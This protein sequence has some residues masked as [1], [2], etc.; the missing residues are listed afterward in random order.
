MV[1]ALVVRDG[2]VVGSGY[3]RR[4]GGPHAE[5]EALDGAGDQARGAALFVTLEPCSHSGRTP[6]C[7]DRVVAAGIHK[8]VACHRDPNPQVSG[9]G[10]ERLRAAGVSVESGFLAERAVRL[11]WRFLTAAVTRRPAVTLKWAMS[12]DGRIATADGHSQWISSPA[13][14]RWGLGQREVHDAIVVGIGTS[15][16]DDPRLGRRLGRA[17][18]DIVRVVL[19]RRLRQPPGA[20]MFDVPGTVVVYTETTSGERRR[21]WDALEGCGATV[22]S[23]E[24]VA[25]ATVLADLFER[26]IRS[27]LVEGGAEIAAAFVG[28]GL[29]DRVAVDCAPLLIGGNSAP[30]PLGGAGFSTLDVAP[31]LD[32]L[33]VERRGEDVILSGFRDRCLPDLCASVAG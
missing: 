26:G 20:R 3:H 32:R 28:A 6:P 18:G 21:R 23:L 31:R 17:R 24:K 14:R 15:L 12:L 1:G 4:V 9:R 2:A 11:N 16:A 33:R 25:P 5:V 13:G 8:V 29:Y 27:V 30:G 7:A 10:F 19:D 22:V